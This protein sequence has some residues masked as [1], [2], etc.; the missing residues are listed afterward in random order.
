[1]VLG[2]SHYVSLASIAAVLAAVAAFVVRAALFD[3]PAA[4]LGYA[5]AGGTLI[6]ATHRDNIRRLLRGEERRLGGR[7]G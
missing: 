1:P 3:A 2:A 4:Y 6:I 7:P 5:F